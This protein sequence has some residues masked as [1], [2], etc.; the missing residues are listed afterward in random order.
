M[1]LRALGALRDA[2]YKVLHDLVAHV[3]LEQGEAHL[4]HGLVDVRLGQAALAALS[5]L[6]VAFSLSERL[7]NAN[8]TPPSVVQAA[9]RGLSPR[10]DTAA[11]RRVAANRAARA[12]PRLYLRRAP[13]AC[14]R[15]PRHQARSWPRSPAAS[16]SARL[17]DVP[18]A[19]AR[20]ARSVPRSPRGKGPRCS[21]GRSIPA[22]CPSAAR[23]KNQRASSGARCSSAT[24]IATSRV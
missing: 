14:A 6:N 3:R 20:Y 21:A 11:P 4:A 13:H 17:Y 5:V 15:K 12:E 24:A 7:S 8:V 10:G 9:Q 23:R 22:A 18:H 16:L 19:L 2:L 1:H